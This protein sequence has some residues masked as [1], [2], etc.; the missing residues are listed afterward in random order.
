MQRIARLAWSEPE[1]AARDGV[2]RS[3]KRREVTRYGW[4]VDDD[5]CDERLPRSRKTYPISVPATSHPKLQPRPDLEGLTMTDT[6]DRTP[7]TPAGRPPGRPGHRCRRSEDGDGPDQPQDKITDDGPDTFDRA[8][9]QRLR[10]EAA[11]HRV[12][13]K[14]A[15]TLAARLVTSMAA[16]TNRL[17]D[18]TDLTFRPDLLEDDGLPDAAKVADAIEKLLARKP[19]L[20]SR[21]PV[22]SEGGQGAYARADAV[23][24]GDLLRPRSASR[25]VILWGSSAIRV[26]D[27]RSGGGRAGVPDLDVGMS[28]SL[29]VGAGRAGQVGAGSARS[30]VRTRASSR[31]WGCR[32]SACARAW[33]VSRPGIVRS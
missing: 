20:A 27:L 7:T 11:G 2:A 10:D 24:L 5:P 32:R 12:R 31:C 25:A 23:S 29:V 8:Y 22:Q 26:V 33:R 18:P 19:H 4:Q 6:A 16:Q 21:R 30:R 14:R 3:M 15:D 13:A 9:V 17:A 28:G 1:Q